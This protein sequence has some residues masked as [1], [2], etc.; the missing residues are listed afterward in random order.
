MQTSSMDA[1][2]G[3]RAGLASRLAAFVALVA[4]V[5]SS[6]LAGLVLAADRVSAAPVWYAN[7]IL[8]GVL[9]RAP[10]R[11]VARHRQDDSA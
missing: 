11:H 2:T 3:P 6:A 7:G 4:L 1:R 10:W 5:A 8:L 9:L